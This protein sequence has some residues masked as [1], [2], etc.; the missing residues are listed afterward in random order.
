MFASLITVPVVVCTTLRI[1]AMLFGSLPI[2]H[3][4]RQCEVT[5]VCIQGCSS[6]DTQDD[7][8]CQPRNH[9]Y[10]SNFLYFGR[11]L[12]GKENTFSTST[13]WDWIEADKSAHNQ[14]V[15]CSSAFICNH[16]DSA[17]STHRRQYRGYSL[18]EYNWPEHYYP[19]DVTICGE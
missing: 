4:R 12:R 15:S 6:C 5:R 3:L 10:I 16:L 2:C 19:S 17:G 14:R 8:S 11:P 18:L 1:E 7:M 13:N 9:Y